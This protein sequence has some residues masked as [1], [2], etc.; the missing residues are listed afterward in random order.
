MT[1]IVLT[2]HAI[3]RAIERMSWTQEQL[4]YYAQASTERGTYMMDNLQVRQRCL[5]YGEDYIAY[6]YRKAIF[7][8]KEHT[9][10]TIYPWKS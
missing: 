1:N 9:L 5:R 6:K 10:I 7:I 8:F 2:T 3:N 4:M